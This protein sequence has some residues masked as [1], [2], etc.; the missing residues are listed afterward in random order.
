M[1]WQIIL[2]AMLMIPLI[3]GIEDCKGVMVARDIPCQVIS[4]WQFPNDCGSYTISVFN[5]TPLLLDTR[6]LANYSLTGRCN[7]TF[8]YTKQGSYLLN[9]SSGDSSKIIIE[10]DDDMI[11]GLVVGIGIISAMLLWFAFK[12]DDKEHFILK[13]LMTLSAI[14]LLIL[15]PTSIFI[16]DLASIGKTFYRTFL[17][18][19]VSFWLYVFLYFCY[20]ILNKFGIIVSGEDEEND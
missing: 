5:Q 7:I 11:L 18:I 20:W 9:W 2:I 4:S 19:F 17:F 10:E 8:N 3:Q 13:L 16:T 6:P 15:I 12:L 14:T 1:K